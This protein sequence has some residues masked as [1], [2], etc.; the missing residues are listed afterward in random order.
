MAV[1]SCY[2]LDEDETMMTSTLYISGVSTNVSIAKLYVVF[3]P[4]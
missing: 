4:N 3:H 1:A 2:T